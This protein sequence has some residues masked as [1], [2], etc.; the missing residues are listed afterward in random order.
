MY[1]SILKTVPLHMILFLLVMM[2]CG[3][4]LDN[5]V[6][7][8]E[9]AHNNHNIEKSITFYSD[10]VRFVLVGGWVAEGKDN[11]K[12][13]FE[14]DF[15]INGSLKFKDYKTNKD[16]VICKVEERNDFFTL[17]NIDAVY[18]EYSKFIFENELIK[19]VQAKLTP[20]SFE[21]IENSFSSFINW[22]SSERSQELDDLKSNGN[23]SFTKEKADK[24]LKLLRTYHGYQKE[25][26]DI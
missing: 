13:R 26:L 17:L 7:L 18:Y 24:W 4:K 12:E 20:E 19:E 9:E 21:T 25:A 16:T 22:V 1:K 14:W 3:S 5:R 10:D 8:L 6:K 23:F 2:S 11:L 15:A